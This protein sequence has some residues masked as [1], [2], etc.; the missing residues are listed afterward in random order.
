MRF[1][2]KPAIKLISRALDPIIGQRITSLETRLHRKTASVLLEI[3]E[4][5]IHADLDGDYLEFG[6]YRADTFAYACGLL[7]RNYPKM[8]F[9]AFDSWEGLPEASGLDDQNGYTSGFKEGQYRGELDE[10]WQKVSNSGID[11]GRVHTIQGW[12]DKTLVPNHPESSPVSK[13]AIAWVDCDYYDSTVPV[14]EYLTPRI[15]DGTVIVFDD[16]RCYR[17]LPNLGMQRA[18]SEWLNK[19][20]QIRLHELLSYSWNGIAFTVEIVK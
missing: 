5:L 3:N 19:N 9:Y 12:F 2:T 10:F 7:G 1:I 11:R 8:R 4:Y 15:S 17:N 20:S 18:C 13:A 14:L 16:W 6:V